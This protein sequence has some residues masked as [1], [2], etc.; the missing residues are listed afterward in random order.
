[1]FFLIKQI[2]LIIKNFKQASKHANTLVYNLR[3]YFERNNKV[4]DFSDIALGFVYKNSKWSDLKNDNIKPTFKLQLKSIGNTITGILMILLVLVHIYFVV[5]KIEE[6]PLQ[7][8]IQHSKESN[9]D[10]CIAPILILGYTVGSLISWF[11]DFFLSFLQSLRLMKF[12]I[13]K[14]KV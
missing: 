6:S 5:H 13:K 3:C 12:N 8:L 1:M 10:W 9:Y 4:R 2:E 14:W 7:V 11:S